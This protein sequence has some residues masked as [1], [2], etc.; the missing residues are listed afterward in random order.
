MILLKFLIQK[1]FALEVGIIAAN[2]STDTLELNQ[3]L[4]LA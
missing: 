1:E 3:P 4:E 2:L